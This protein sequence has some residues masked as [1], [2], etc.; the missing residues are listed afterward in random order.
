[1]AMLPGQLPGQASMPVPVLDAAF[2]HPALHGS[3]DCPVTRDGS[4]QE[5]LMVEGGTITI[6]SVYS[7]G[8]LNSLMEALQ[9]SGVDLTQATISVEVDL[10]KRANR[11]NVQNYCLIFVQSGGE[12]AILYPFFIFLQL[13][14]LEP[15]ED[16]NVFK[17][18]AYKRDAPLYLEWAPDDILSED[19]NFINDEEESCVVCEHETEQVLLE[20]EL[21]GK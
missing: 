3:G 2:S 13:V 14:F 21:E 12:I 9:N 5:E 10:G 20:Q 19:P 11:T 8:L 4:Q 16:R 7:Q 15:G 1:M 18:L 17:V 6:S